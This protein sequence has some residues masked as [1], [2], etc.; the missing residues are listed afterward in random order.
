M[1]QVT[2]SD[3]PAEVAELAD[4]FS[5]AHERIARAIAVEPDLAEPFDAQRA[6][7]AAL[8]DLTAGLR[9]WYHDCAPAAQRRVSLSAARELERL[10]H[11]RSA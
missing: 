5:D 7:G 6:I 8:T 3:M 11:G 9:A 2:A 10:V 4:L 1:A